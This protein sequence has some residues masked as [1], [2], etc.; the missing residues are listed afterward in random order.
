MRKTDPR[1]HFHLLPE[2]ALPDIEPIRFRRS[3]PS[4]RLR[5]PRPLGS[6]I[7]TVGVGVPERLR[8]RTFVPEDVTDLEVDSSSP[9]AHHRPAWRTNT[10]VRATLHTKLEE[11]RSRVGVLSSSGKSDWSEGGSGVEKCSVRLGMTENT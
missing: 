10:P 2:L 11:A 4:L 3:D 6:A 9:S 8:L 1:D 5:L 7:S